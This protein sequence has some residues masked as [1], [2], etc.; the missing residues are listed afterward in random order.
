M[1]FSHHLH[2]DVRLFEEMPRLSAYHPQLR[3]L[4]SHNVQRSYQSCIEH[5]QDVGD[6]LAIV[7]EAIL[8][9]S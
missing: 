3:S 5:M 4:T 6:R 2:D 7:H 9:R 1:L 8:I